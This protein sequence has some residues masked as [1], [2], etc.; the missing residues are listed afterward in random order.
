MRCV[1]ILISL[2]LHCTD[3]MVDSVKERDG[4]RGIPGELI[5]VRLHRN[6]IYLDN[7]DDD[8]SGQAKRTM[9]S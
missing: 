4:D 1:K 2:W 7:T 6:D 5:S 8:K 9:K 3:I